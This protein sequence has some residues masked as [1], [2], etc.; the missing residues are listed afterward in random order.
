MGMGKGL[1]AV[2]NALKCYIPYLPGP[3]SSVD[4]HLEKYLPN[5]RNCWLLVERTEEISSHEDRKDQ[6]ATKG[7][8]T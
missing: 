2:Y 8:K 3:F 7:R 1:L 6:A 5:N 4:A